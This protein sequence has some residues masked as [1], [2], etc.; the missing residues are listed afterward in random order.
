MPVRYKYLALFLVTVGAVFLMYSNT[1]TRFTPMVIE[2][3]SFHYP[4]EIDN[5]NFRQNLRVVLNDWN[6]QYR[7]GN[8]SSV[9][10][11]RTVLWDKELLLNLTNRTLDSGWVDTLR[12][13]LNIR[14]VK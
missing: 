4:S 14:A 11:K 10:V 2:N 6:I 13:S 8:D 9:L 12:N 5:E 1:Y 7:I 3:D